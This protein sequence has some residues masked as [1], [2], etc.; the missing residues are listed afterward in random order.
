MTETI[1]ESRETMRQVIEA[2]FNKSEPTEKSD[3]P[4]DKVEKTESPDSEIVENKQLEDKEV[5]AKEEKETAKPEE[6]KTENP[7]EEPE[8][9]IKL[10]ENLPPYVKDVLQEVK[11]KKIVDSVVK[12]HK[13]MLASMQRKSHELSGHKKLAEGLNDV[14]SKYGKAQVKNKIESIEGL[15]KFEKVAEKNPK[16]A[17]RS[18]M[19]ALK[20]NP[21]EFLNDIVYNGDK[22]KEEDTQSD[23]KALREELNS[24][25]RNRVNED[26]K[27]EVEDFK[28]AKDSEG[29]L[30]YPYFEDL[31]IEMANQM[32][33]YPD[34]SLEKL[35]EKAFRLNDDLYLKSKN[36][37]K[38]KIEEQ[39][40]KKLK[41]EKAKKISK[42][43]IS[44]RPSNTTP[45][46]WRA[47]LRLDLE[48][49]LKDFN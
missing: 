41:L 9:E 37:E 48:P 39:T 46:D 27:R 17:L 16:K 22:L 30:K 45:K 24:Y 2:E 15:L 6:D 43:N 7:N 18:L 25:K 40:K 31:K 38:A 28:K 26:V 10:P 29:N 5:E 23:I 20:V 34:L 11:D 13:N 32:K 35:Y 33:V 12:A 47:K 44:S 14:F 8:E 1:E 42:Q 49:L 21:E 19:N 3:V 4:E 36:D